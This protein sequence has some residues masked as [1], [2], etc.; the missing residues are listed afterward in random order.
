MAILTRVPL[1][2]KPGYLYF[3]GKDGYI[4][5]APMKHNA[6]GQRYRANNERVERSGRFVFINKQGLVESKER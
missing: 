2:R 3:I 6:G 4:W 1:Q 5:G